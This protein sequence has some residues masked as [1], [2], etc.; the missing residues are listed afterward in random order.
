MILQNSKSDKGF[1]K[2]F[3]KNTENVY[4][5]VC[6]NLN[7][8]D[9]LDLTLITGNAWFLDSVAVFDMLSKKIYEFVCKRW[10][11]GVDGDHKTYRDLLLDRERAFI[12]GP[13]DFKY[14]SD[15]ELVNFICFPAI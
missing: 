9:N 1:K 5:K 13:E 8:M 15:E 11:S 7:S 12:Q 4:S 14:M 3:T 6:F 2:K 10:L